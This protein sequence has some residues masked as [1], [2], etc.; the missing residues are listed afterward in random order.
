MPST[1]A[2]TPESIGPYRVL[3]LLG[4]R[5]PT[6]AYKAADASGRPVVVEVMSRALSS[7]PAAVERLH[8]SVRRLAELAHPNVLSFLGSGEDD[9]QV[10]LVHEP[11]E[12]PTL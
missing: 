2:S 3:S 5:H 10:Y 1:S 11:W 7:D 6:T 9:G 8:Q 12:G 4:R